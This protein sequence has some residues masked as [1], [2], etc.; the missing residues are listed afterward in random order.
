M[1]RLL[2]VLVPLCIAACEQRHVPPCM[3]EPKFNGWNDLYVRGA[4]VGSWMAGPDLLAA[5]REFGCVE[6]LRVG[7]VDG[8]AR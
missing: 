7:P 1:K 2:L 3:A 5:E 4:R 8:G 6:A